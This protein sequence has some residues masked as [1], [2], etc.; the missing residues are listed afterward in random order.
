MVFVKVIL[1]LFVA[2]VVLVSA[3]PPFMMY[4]SKN[5]LFPSM[6]PPKSKIV[7]EIWVPQRAAQRKPKTVRC[8]LRKT[9]PFVWSLTGRASQVFC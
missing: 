8:L 5:G 7:E 9:V 1:L 4:K 3:F 2:N 6:E